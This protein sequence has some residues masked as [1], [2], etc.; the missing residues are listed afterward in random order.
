MTFL[1]DEFMQTSFIF[2]DMELVRTNV[3]SIHV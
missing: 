3:S 2:D 1:M